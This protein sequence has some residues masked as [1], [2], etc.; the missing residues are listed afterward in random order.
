M[1]RFRP[2]GSNG[3]KREALKSRGFLRIGKKP[4]RGRA[5]SQSANARRR[6][7]RLGDRVSRGPG[8]SRYGEARRRGGNRNNSAIAQQTHSE[9]HVRVSRTWRTGQISI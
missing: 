5:D 8:H 2:S 1:L 4:S 9:P 7:A 3:Q 6:E